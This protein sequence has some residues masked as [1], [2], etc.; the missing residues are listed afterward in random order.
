MTQKNK[1]PG[2]HKSP[3]KVKTH[4]KPTG[5]TAAQREIHHR[6]EVQSGHTLASHARH[7]RAENYPDLYRLIESAQAA[8]LARRRL[9]G[10]MVFRH[11]G[12][13]YA[14]RF[15]SLDRIIIEDRLTGRFIAS[16]DFFAL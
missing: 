11:E 6:I 8:A 13:S 2:A 12:R 15:T 9:R 16:S 10:R 4:R 7:W 1:K 3:G 5:I 14:A